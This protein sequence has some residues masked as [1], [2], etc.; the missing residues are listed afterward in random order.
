MGCS[1]LTSPCFMQTPANLKHTIGGRNQGN[2]FFVGKPNRFCRGMF[3]THQ[4]DRSDIC[5]LGRS[6][7]LWITQ[8]GQQ[9]GFGLN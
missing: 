7:D 4:D 9:H 8:P 5:H 2:T 6:D 3:A 1:R